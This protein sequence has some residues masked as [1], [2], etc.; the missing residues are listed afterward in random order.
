[1]LRDKH[2]RP[3]FPYVYIQECMSLICVKSAFI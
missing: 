2:L 1:M 3:E